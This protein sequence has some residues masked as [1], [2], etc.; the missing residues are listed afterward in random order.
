LGYKDEG[1]GDEYTYQ[2]DEDY[3]EPMDEDDGF[4]NGANGS[5]RTSGRRSARNAS[6][7]ANGTDTWSLWRGERRS[8]RLGAP[9]EVQL[10]DFPRKRARTEE[11][12]A[13][14]SSADFG[15]DRYSS[16]T[17]LGETSSAGAAKKHGAASVKPTEI[18]ME[19]V[20]GKKK[21]KFWFYAVEPI[22]G[23][24]AMSTNGA[25]SSGLNGHKNNGHAGPPDKEEP[26][27]GSSADDIDM[28]IDR[29]LEGSLSPAP[30]SP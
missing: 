7:S 8:S 26:V 22:H 1:E 30:M 19:Q 24:V 3:D 27:P 15:H 21:S 5:R 20:G 29:S 18:A 4:G 23:Q 28:D 16:G 17:P 25:S 6:G 13:S 2:E 9:P 11:S 14:I 12:T 10:D